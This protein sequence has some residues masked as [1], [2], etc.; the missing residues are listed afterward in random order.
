M[1]ISCRLDQY[2]L[3]PP[4]LFTAT[5]CVNATLCNNTIQYETSLLTATSDRTCA[6][7]T[8]C[9]STQFESILATMTSD[10]TC[11]NRVT[12]DGEFRNAD[13]ATL[14]KYTHINGIIAYL[15]DG[16]SS[17]NLTKTSVLGHN[18]QFYGNPDATLISLPSL[19][20]KCLIQ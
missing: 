11:T 17:L 8:I 12:Y 10:R 6:L 20:S 1:R 16:F 4:T 5:H 19:L 2:Q 14:Q 18:L 7:L 3:H 9:G 13:A 15:N